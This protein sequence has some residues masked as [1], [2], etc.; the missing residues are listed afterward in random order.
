MIR[1]F[2]RAFKITNENIILATPLVLFLFLLSIYLEIA[3]NAPQNIQA[4][5][6]L[7][8]TILFM[9]SAFFAGWFY[10]VQ[11][12]IDLDKAEFIID[13]DK[14]KASFNLIKEIPVGIGEYFLSFIG[15]F[16][17]Y[18]ALILLGAF[19]TYKIGLHFIGNIGITLDQLKAAFG[20]SEAMKALVTSM[21]AAE[22]IKLNTWNMLFLGVSAF[23]SFITMFWAP[24]VIR[25]TK[26]PL[27]ALLKA[28]RFILRKPLGSII[29]F[30][31]ISFI[32]FMV[33]FVNAISA[34]NP[35]LYFFSML[36][37]FYFIVYIIV[38]IFL[39]YDREI[40]EKENNSDSGSDSF[41]EE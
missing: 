40:E 2:K 29:L 4:S 17:L 16:I 11:R 22:L 38:L 19:C 15:G 20:S 10:M 35:I 6:L 9:L 24:Q 23:Y 14:S 33:S 41:G 31:Y 37:Y 1:Y 30:I 25:Y 36:L 8:F 21:S 39:Y 5:V 26:N 7:L 32:N 27:I 12:A 3:K 18:T 34:V 13:E 28:I